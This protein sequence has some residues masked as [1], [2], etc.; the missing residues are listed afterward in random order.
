MIKMTMPCSITDLVM[1]ST[2]EEVNQNKF[3]PIEELTVYDLMGDDYY[4]QIH[5]VSQKNIKLE[6]ENS[7]GTIYSKDS[8][9]HPCAL[10]SLATFCRTFLRA[11]QKIEEKI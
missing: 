7:D 9:V 10:D 3:I 1:P 5:L 4:C 2:S 11:Y 6:I 8:C